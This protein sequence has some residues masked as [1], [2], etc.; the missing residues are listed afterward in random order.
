MVLGVACLT[1]WAVVPTMTTAQQ[2]STPVP[3][4][5]LPPTWTP[6]PSLTPSHTPTVTPS[7]NP[8]I[9]PSP[10]ATLSRGLICQRFSLTGA[11]EPDA[12]LAYND[13]L[14]FSWGGA[15]P[16]SRVLLQ[17]DGPQA[18]PVLLE[19]APETGFFSFVPLSVLPY[20]GTYTWRISL[21]LAPYGELCTD[22]AQ[23]TFFREPWW[24]R[25]LPNPLAPYLAN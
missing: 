25:P 20:W 5:T 1:A 10:T 22:T 21:L 8:T 24:Q 18:D 13:V 16:D 4:N 15:P 11:P 17:L 7:P 2:P 14:G 9:T 6:V 3:R 12:S 23:G 19:F